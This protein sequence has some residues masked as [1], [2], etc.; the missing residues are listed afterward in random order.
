MADYY[1]LLKRAV[2]GLDVNDAINRQQLYNRAELALLTQLKG[3]M[4]ALDKEEIDREVVALRRDIERLDREFPL[5]SR[6]D[7]TRKPRRIRTDN[8]ART[9]NRLTEWLVAGVKDRA[10]VQTSPTSLPPL[11][12]IPEQNESRAFAFIQTRTGALDIIPDPPL[13]PYDAEQNQ[14]YARI[15][16]LL[17]QFNDQFATQQRSQVSKQIDDFLR[18]P[19]EWSQVISKRMVWACAN[20]LRSKLAQHDAVKDSSEPSEAKLPPDLAEALRDPIQVWNV[21]VLGDAD[22]VS[23]DA[24]R[25]GPTEQKVVEQAWNAAQPFLSAAG[26][27][28]Q[29]TTVRAAD[30]IDLTMK[31]AGVGGESI[32]ATQARELAAQTSRNLASKIIRDAYLG[33]L[34]TINPKT[35]EDLI[36]AEEFAKG[37]A[38]EAG[39]MAV[40]GVTAAGVIGAGY[41][42]SHAGSY[43]AWVAANADVVKELVANAFGGGQVSQIVD[44]ILK[45][46]NRT[47][48]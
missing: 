40:R 25:F 16:Y 6:A 29:I 12:A 45:V 37:A 30:A 31:A 17:E 19:P 7:A 11:S 24:M 10:G 35:P 33:A 1:T 18:Q 47:K 15:R 3:V 44:F 9:V 5:P 46:F 22:L 14:L 34:G 26:K 23:F 27:D 38:S 42:I 2:E 28:R 48:N 43:I 36:R 4:P 20:A 13:D 39:K 21:F 41:V 32:H 8:Y